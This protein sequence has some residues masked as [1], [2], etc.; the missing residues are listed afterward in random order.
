MLYQSIQTIFNLFI[1]WEQNTK[2][3]NTHKNSK[4]HNFLL[5]DNIIVQTHNM[6][7]KNTFEETIT[8][9]ER[10]GYGADKNQEP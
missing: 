8:Q 7:L 3:V 2:P 5:F 10:T 1:R 6:L 4:L 9:R